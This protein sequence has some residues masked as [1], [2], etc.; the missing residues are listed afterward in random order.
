MDEAA[1]RLRF[2]TAAAAG[3]EMAA[4]GV[5]A[6]ALVK[7]FL[8]VFAFLT[9]CLMIG[10]V[11]AGRAE[12]RRARCARGAGVR[13]SACGLDAGSADE[14][15]DGVLSEAV[16]TTSVVTIAVKEDVFVDERGGLRG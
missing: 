10:C 16:L 15:S 11:F 7:T 1:A 6:G 12:A 3:G 14:T 4:A 9:S 5:A 13:L 8:D 2:L